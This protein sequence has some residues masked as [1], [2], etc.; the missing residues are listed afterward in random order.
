MYKVRPPTY[1]RTRPSVAENGRASAHDARRRLAAQ[2]HLGRAC[3][4]TRFQVDV[5]TSP[6][7]VRRATRCIPVIN[8]TVICD[9]RRSKLGYTRRKKARFSIRK[10]V[11]EYLA[12]RSLCYD[13]ISAES[14]QRFN[15]V[16]F[17]RCCQVLPG[18]CASVRVGL[19]SRGAKK[20]SRY[21]ARIFPA[22]LCTKFM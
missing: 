18:E 5:S 3:A 17:A 13:E 14:R 7:H 22:R 6:E 15:G 2:S 12:R 19:P 4:C 20:K 8:E 11:L 10:L 16:V 21:L 1:Y 9:S